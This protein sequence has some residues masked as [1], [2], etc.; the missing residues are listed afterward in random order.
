MKASA[1]VAA[2]CAFQTLAT[3]DP[4][5][6]SAR[7]EVVGQLRDRAGVPIAGVIVFAAQDGT[8][9]ISGFAVSDA[10][11]RITLQLPRLR[12]NFGVLSSSHGVA[13]IVHTGL[14]SFVMELRPLAQ[15][16]PQRDARTLPLDLA[17]ARVIRGRVTD[18]TGRELAG[19]RVEVIRDASAG[20]VT[21]TAV[22]M[23]DARGRFALGLV[24][25]RFQLRAGAPGLK[26]ARG[27][28]RGDWIEVTMAIDAQ[29]EQVSVSQGGHVLRFRL[30]RS[31]DPEIFPPAPVRAWLCTSYGI[32][33]RSRIPTRAERNR[34]KKYWYLD[35]LRNPP[36]NPAKV[37]SWNAASCVPEDNDLALSRNPLGAAAYGRPLIER[38]GDEDLPASIFDR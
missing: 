23:T 34:I 2:V 17:E 16:L 13:S 9:Q 5:P 15:T 28:R 33:V 38:L 24:S 25:G 11:G 6:A 4:A 1:A 36:P 29:T 26:L 20:V 8:D 32:V 14:A 30:D 7:I 22:T 12:H 37:T 31:L 35:L 10:G 3:G 21:T 27:A 19:V 18:E